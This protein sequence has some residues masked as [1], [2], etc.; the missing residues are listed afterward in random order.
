MARFIA[1][2]A[3]DSDIKLPDD[4]DRLTWN[5]D[6]ENFQLAI[7]NEKPGF[8]Y[9]EKALVAEIVFQAS[10][11]SEARECCQDILA[12]ALNSLAWISLSMIRQAQLIRVVD[13]EPGKTMR[14]AL[15]L[16]QSPKIATAIPIFNQ[17]LMDAASQIYPSQKSE[18]SQTA[19][20]WFRLGISGD[21]V[22]E[23]FTYFWF[24]LETAAE[25]LKSAG[26][27]PHL[28]PICEEKLFCSNCDCYPEHR[29]FS[30][31]AIRDLITQSFSDPDEGM[32][33]F[34]ALVK[35]RHA[36]MHGRRMSSA[37]K[38]LSFD[39]SEVTNLLAKIAR[40]AIL[41]MGDFSNYSDHKFEVMLIEADD[42][43]RGTA[44]VTGHVQ[45]V[46]GPDPNNP[47]LPK[48]SG[49]AVSIRH[50]GQP[51]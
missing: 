45:T 8:A 26:K 14:E 48:E 22:E 51:E 38:N 19:L 34:K 29:R 36:L 39:D 35:V 17:E 11:I 46:F 10:D 20:R 37:T 9:T 13:W 49:I 16:A 40:N 44:I 4:L 25:A 32:I 30:A 24:A 41:W 28:C 3:L 15:I 33:A 42:V 5:N 6:A 1:E 27:V 43:V 47:R 50:P 2:F 7:K 31:D 12:K 21:N 18:K 23:Q